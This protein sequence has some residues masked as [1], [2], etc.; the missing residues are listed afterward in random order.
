MIIRKPYAFLIKNFKKLH[1]LLLA[2]SIYVF[3]QINDVNSFMNTFMKLGV[4]DSTT[5][6]VTRHITFLLSFSCILIFALSTSILFLLHHKK[7]PWKIYLFPIIEYLAL[8]FVLEMVKGFFAN[9]TYGI[10]T[11]DLNFIRDLF[12]IFMIVQIVPIT[13]FVM[14]VLGLDYKKFGFNLDEE[15]LQLSESDREEIEVALDIDINTFK[16][17]FKRLWRNVIYFYND[18]KKICNAIGGILVVITLYNGYKYF[19]VVNRSYKEGNNF[20]VNGYTIKINKTYFTD[21]DYKGDIISNNSNFVILD[22]SVTN[23]YSPRTIKIENFHIK[24]GSSKYDYI[25]TKSIYANEFQDLGKVYDD[26]V[27]IGRGKTA[28][29]II[30]FRVDKILKKNR[31]VLYFQENSNM[32]R[33]IKL[34][35][36][37]YSKFKETTNYSL[38]DDMEV[39]FATGNKEIMSFDNYDFTDEVEYQ[40]RNCV[41]ESCETIKKTYT[42]DDLHKVL[43]I[44]FGSEVFD[45]KNMIDFLS[46]YG[47]IYYEDSNKELVKLD[48]DNAVGKKYYGKLVYLKVPNEIVDSNNVYIEFTVRNLKYHY[49][50]VGG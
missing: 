48:I 37:D 47:K 24:N 20:D 3:F 38:M 40:V 11:S 16:R 50:I 8:F 15:F 21:K 31:F 2:L 44:K 41:Y 6:P 13:V 18:H 7:K 46:K 10:A 19:F 29:F 32:L 34:K 43:E 1:M 45:G 28:N 5:D 49:Q 36:S 23:H 27:D 30:I 26:K 17:L 42:S 9:Y 22:V 25:T 12:S 39:N 35:V 14:R 33:R 4:Y